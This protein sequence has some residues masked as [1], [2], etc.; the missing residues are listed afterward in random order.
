MYNDI[1]IALDALMQRKNQT[2][3]I[4]HFRKL[5]KSMGNPQD[6]L[7]TIHIGGTNGKGSTTNYTRSILQEAGFRVGTFTSPHLIVHNDRIRINNVPIADDIF[8]NYIN[9]T[10]PLWDEHHLSMFE[11]DMLISILYFLDAGVDYVIYEVGLGGRLDATNVIN[12][13]ICAITNIGLDHQGILGD[14]IAAIAHEKAGIIKEGVQLVTTIQDREALDVMINTVHDHHG[15]LKQLC[16][17]RYKRVDKSYYFEHENVT[18]TL[19]N[20]GSYQVGNAALAAS[21][22]RFIIPELAA[23]VFQRG[24]R[25]A[26]WAGRFEEVLPNVYVDGAHNEMGI[27]RLVQSAE[28]LPRPHVAV[29]AALKDKEYG[30]MVHQLTEAFDTVIVTEF[31]FF[32]AARAQELAEN[33]NVQTMTPYTQAIDTALENQGTGSI[34]VTGSLYFISEA[35]EYLIKKVNE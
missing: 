32:R 29:F 31:D 3:G 15:K 16:I 14:T 17:P 22:V 20:Q 4:T 7:Q 8:L 25:L 21:I 6:K 11:I 9:Q 18:Y 19:T 1:H 33:Q 30:N 2:Y 23:D 26:S 13:E 5:L 12:P 27:E 34:I 24:V 10:Y 28:I 35:R